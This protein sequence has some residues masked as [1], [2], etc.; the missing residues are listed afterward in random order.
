MGLTGKGPI[1]DA[2]KRL[3]D[4]TDWILKMGL[5]AIFGLI[6]GKVAK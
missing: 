4:I 3:W 6:G 5:G 2:A 1:A